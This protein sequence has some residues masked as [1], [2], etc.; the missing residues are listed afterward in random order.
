MRDFY[1]YISPNW[2][3]GSKTAKIFTAGVLRVDYKCLLP[4]KLHTPGRVLLP[5]YSLNH[6]H[7]GIT[8]KLANLTKMQLALHCGFTV[9]CKINQTFVKQIKFVEID[10]A[11]SHA[12]KFNI[13][14]LTNPA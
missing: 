1:F 10:N 7:I 2:G 13:S 8:D 4:A 5:N 9:D 6:A 12:Q 3:K 11:G 14:S